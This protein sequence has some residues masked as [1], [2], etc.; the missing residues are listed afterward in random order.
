MLDAILL[1]GVVGLVVVAHGDV[2]AARAQHAARVARI[3]AHDEPGRHDGGHAR[4]AAARGGR[5]QVT[6]P[7][8]QPTTERRSRYQKLFR[9]VR[10]ARSSRS[11][12]ATLTEC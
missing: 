9:R 2:G 11:F 7:Q 4:A 10:R 3:G 1:R 12:A 6:Q 8:L 5:G